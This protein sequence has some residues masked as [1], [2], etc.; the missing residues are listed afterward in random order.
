MARNLTASNPELK[1]AE[2][3]LGAVAIKRKQGARKKRFR[4]CLTNFLFQGFT[5]ATLTCVWTPVQPW[6]STSRYLT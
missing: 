1:W 4:I 6:Q 5:E 3:K 2:G